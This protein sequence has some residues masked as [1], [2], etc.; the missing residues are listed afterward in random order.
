[1]RFSNR[2]GEGCSMVARLH[3]AW[4][5]LIRTS[6]EDALTRLTAPRALGALLSGML[7]LNWMGGCASSPPGAP[8]LGYWDFSP[9]MIFPA[10]RSLDRPE[11][12]VA[13]ADGRLI[14]ADRVHGLRL[15][16]RDGTS[17][18]FGGMPAAGY[19]SESSG[20]SRAAN[21]VSLEPGGTHLIVA[22]ILEGS[23][24]R[25]AIDGGAATRVYR[26]PYGINT[27][28]RDSRGSI[29]FTQSTTNTREDDEARNFAAVDVP[30]PDG[31]LWRLPYHDGRFAERAELIRDGLR[32]AN[33]LALDEERGT[34]YVAEL[35]NDRVLHAELDVGR[36]R[37]GPLRTLVE[38][39]LPDN[40]ELDEHGR[41]WVALPARNEVGVIDPATGS[42]RAVFSAQTPEQV[43]LSEEFVRRG[44]AGQPRMEL[45]SPAMWSDLPGPITGLILAKDAV[46][47]TTI[48]DGMVR[49]PR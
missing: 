13:L 2:E 9:S 48:G 7:T 11:D 44:V 39:A 6:K 40:L 15:V 10:D 46:Y 25:V 33:G 28:V 19:P 49:L 14:V 22:D 23:I 4:R 47:L 30:V 36:G 37:I 1:M 27:A 34:L 43:E 45:F 26:H 8:A 5:C 18:P 38:L 41:L 16:H 31:S 29:W 35:S 12:G 17:E 32:Y 20:W 24:Y 42:Y 3:P 21:G